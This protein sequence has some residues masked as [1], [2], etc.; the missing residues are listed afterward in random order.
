MP[1]QVLCLPAGKVH[2]SLCFTSLWS[3]MFHLLSRLTLRSKYE[4]KYRE[5]WATILLICRD[6]TIEKINHMHSPK[7]TYQGKKCLSVLLAK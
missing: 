1:V 5:I 3:L 2:C 7:I 4:H 6:I